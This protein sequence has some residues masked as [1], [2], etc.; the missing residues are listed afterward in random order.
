MSSVPRIIIA[1][2][3]PAFRLSVGNYLREHGYPHVEDI[4]DGYDLYKTLLTLQFDL[5]L[6]DVHLPTLSGFKVLDRL[7]S[8]NKPVPPHII[9]TSDMSPSITKEGLKYHALGLLIKPVTELQVLRSVQISWSQ[10]LE[11]LCGMEENLKLKEALDR[12]VLMNKAK[13]LISKRYG[14]NDEESHRR[15]LGL[16]MRLSIPVEKVSKQVIE[17]GGYLEDL[18]LGS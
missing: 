4:H 18:V 6:L 2:D 14:I 13:R 10:H 9:I 5:V 16:S 1:D 7:H 15:L 17:K 8:Q 12:R 3:D 11:K